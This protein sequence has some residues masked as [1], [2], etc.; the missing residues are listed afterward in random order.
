MKKWIFADDPVSD[1]E[2]YK[3]PMC[4]ELAGEDLHFIMDKDE[5]LSLS[6]A[7]FPS[8]EV[9]VGGSERGIRYDCAKIDAQIFYLSFVL[10]ES[11]VS[12]LFDRERGLITRTIT[13]LDAKTS[14]SF[15]AA[16]GIAER[17]TFSQDLKDNTVYWTLGVEDTSM[18]KI[19]YTDKGAEI[20]RPRIK[21][22]PALSA[23]DFLA[24]KATDYIYL[25]N[26]IIMSG[27]VRNS[28]NLLSNFQNMTCIG[29]IYSISAENHTTYRSFAGF[30]R[31]FISE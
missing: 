6:F 22:A 24:V 15:G 23:S 12:C 7:G 19:V 20:T 9:R 2:R 8:R 18:F 10:M 1:L 31:F 29:S 27:G 17:H 4:Y 13:G 25:Q 30:G 28:I 5:A 26:A 21:D 16:E 3:A 14:I 11:C